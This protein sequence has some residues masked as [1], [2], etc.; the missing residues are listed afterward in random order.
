[1]EGKAGHFQDR[2]EGRELAKAVVAD[3]VY[4]IHKRWEV[5]KCYWEG[6]TRLGGGVET[7]G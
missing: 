4:E 3:T 7:G 2:A 5:R 1:M 6:N